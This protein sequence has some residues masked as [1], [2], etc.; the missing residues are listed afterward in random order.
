MADSNLL[1]R[2]FQAVVISYVIN[3]NINIMVKYIKHLTIQTVQTIVNR[4][5]VLLY[6]ASI[7][8]VVVI[9]LLEFSELAVKV[10]STFNWLQG[11]YIILCKISTCGRGKLYLIKQ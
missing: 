8:C 10:H 7:A 3:Y 11:M 2:K 1:D 4:G 9:F 6:F 5:Y